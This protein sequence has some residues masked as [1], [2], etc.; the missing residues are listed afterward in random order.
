MTLK[1]Q[2]NTDMEMASQGRV[3][4]EQVNSAPNQ[5]LS[6]K[7]IPQPE[8]QTSQTVQSDLLSPSSSTIQPGTELIPFQNINMKD[9]LMQQGRLMPGCPLQVNVHNNVY[10]GYNN[11]NSSQSSEL[12]ETPTFPQLLLCSL[13][14][15]D[16]EDWKMFA[17]HL[18]LDTFV[19]SIE[20]NVK[21]HGESPMQLLMDKWWKSKG[22]K[23]KMDELKHAL[24]KMNRQDILDDFANA[25]EECSNQ[26]NYS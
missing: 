23:A 2:P 15:L 24:K 25:L 4:Q 14:R 26:S 6:A 10:H 11:S 21:I 13:Q 16:V 3:P 12:Y 17:F 18:K 20:R 5:S 9:F 7:N 22:R 8:P 19:E 1:T